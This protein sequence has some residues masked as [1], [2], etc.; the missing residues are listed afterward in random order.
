MNVRYALW[1]MLLIGS[2]SLYAQN[3]NRSDLK[4]LE[5]EDWYL[6]T[7]SEKL[8]AEAFLQSYKEELGFGPLDQLLL[9][10]TSY[11]KDGSLH[12]HYQQMHKNVPVRGGAFILHLKGDGV[13]MANGE[14][15]RELDQD[16]SPVLN[17]A[18]AFR[19]ALSAYPSDQYYWE[20]QGKSRPLGELF[21]LDPQFSKIGSEYNLCYRFDI[22]SVFPEDRNWVYINAH[23]GEFEMAVSRIHSHD[24][25]TA[26]TKYSGNQTIYTSYDSDSMMYV[27]HDSLTGGGIFTYNM[28]QR[29]NKNTAIDFY[30]DDNHWNNFNANFDEAATDAHWGTERVYH[31]FKDNHNWLSYNNLDSALRS[32]V[33]YDSN[34]VNAF[35]NGSHMTYG[36]GNGTG[37]F[38]LI[39]LDVV[40]HEIAHGVTQNSAGLIY[41]EEAGSLNESFSDIFGAAVEFAYDPNGG[42]W[43]MGEDFM[44]TGNGLRNMKNPGLFNH[45][46]TYKGN[47]WGIGF[48]EDNGYVHSNS[49]VQNFWYYL[50]SDGDVG[51]NDNGDA[52]EVEGLGYQKAADIAFYNLSNHLTVFSDHDDAR[53]GAIAGAIALYGPCSNEY[54]QTANAWYAVGVGKPT[55][56]IDLSVEDILLPNRDCGLGAS[57]SLIVALKNNSCAQSIP[58]G[59]NLSFSYTLNNGSPQIMSVSLSNAL[60]ADSIIY[61]QHNQSLDLSQ[62]GNYDIEVEISYSAD[63]LEYNNSLEQRVRHESYQN[64]EWK[65]LRVISPQSSCDL[66]DSTLIELSAVFLGCDSLVAGTNIDLD[67]SGANGSQS[68]STAIGSDVFY[69]DTISLSFNSLE[70]LSAR[71]AYTFNFTLNYP[72]DPNPGNNRIFN[73]G[74]LKPY[75]LLGGKIGFEDFAYLDSLIIRQAPNNGSRRNSVASQGN[76]GFEI[77]GG[78]FVNYPE[79]VPIPTSDSAVWQ[80]NEDFRSTFCTCVDATNESALALNF[81]LQQA[82]TRLIRRRRNESQNRPQTSSLRVLVNGQQVSET[83]TPQSFDS[84]TFQT[85]VVDLSAYAGQYFEL[86]FETHLLVDERTNGITNDGDIINLD[87]I[88]L[89]NSG[90]GLVE[91]NPTEAAGFSLFPNPN[92]GHFKIHWRSAQAGSYKMWVQDAQGRIVFRRNIETKSGEQAWDFSAKMPAGLYFVQVQMPNGQV[93][94]KEM[95]IQ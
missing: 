93:E 62:V 48:F 66:G 41:M 36:D 37:F 91:Q 44:N 74:V 10:R 46:H 39:S 19:K 90:I 6:Y 52:Y 34:Y 3:E 31:Y 60:L 42:D 87:N 85:Q 59:T 69:G 67:Y 51:V 20:L 16:V 63:T 78:A 43:K 57:E 68:I 27:L 70:D 65:L 53:M 45:P 81:D 13:Y 56:S 8:S 25:G 49:G 82:Y 75:E 28:Q 58:A 76:R 94:T 61:L 1:A 5:V 55:G 89:S 92:S 21:L 14:V 64:A 73:Y 80:G 17:E 22:H 71:G 88:Y 72:G 23:S 77:V 33:H 7:G 50:L 15:V 30:D 24:T 35:W 2:L 47:N 86:C 84:D 9:K 83:Y 18:E 95:L 54:I 12:L 29:T 40:A 4:S 38:P 32:Y 11:G 79:L 26:V